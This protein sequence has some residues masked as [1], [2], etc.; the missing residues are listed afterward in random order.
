MV[1]STK[2]NIWDCNDDEDEDRAEAGVDEVAMRRLAVKGWQTA[3]RKDTSIAMR[4]KTAS[5]R[6]IISLCEM[7]DRT[8][9]WGK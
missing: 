4:R 1:G 8:G 3:T 5:G 9:L 2:S 7:F 6:G